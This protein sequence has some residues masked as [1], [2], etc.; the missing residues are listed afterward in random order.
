M[1]SP[2]QLPRQAGGRSVSLPGLPR[3]RLS[4]A[5]RAGWARRGQ[6]RRAKAENGPARAPVRD[7]RS[8]RRPSTAFT[9]MAYG[10]LAGDLSCEP[11]AFG[12]RRV[13]HLAV[14]APATAHRSPTSA[15]TS[16]MTVFDPASTTLIRMKR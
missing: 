15:T 16:Q 4:A 9:K 6:P 8:P 3:A 5:R 14:C 7:G 2:L 1:S 13:L 11:D 12:S 10:F